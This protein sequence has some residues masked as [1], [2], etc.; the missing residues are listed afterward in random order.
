MASTTLDL[1][2]LLTRIVEETRRVAEAEIAVLLMVD[3]TA[4]ALVA[5][6]VA[7]EEGISMPVGWTIPLDTPGMEVGILARG[8]AYY[9][10]RALD[11]PNVIPAYLPYMEQLGVRNFCG[12]ALRA[13]EQPIGELYVINR[14]AGFGEDEVRLLRALAGYAANAIENARLFEETRQRSEELSAL[15]RVTSAVSR[16]LELEEVLR[17][18]LAQVLTL[19]G[20]EVGLISLVRPATGQMYL[21]VHR[22]LPEPLV[23]RLLEAGMGGTL[24]DLVYQLGETVAVEDLAQGA[25]ADVGGLVE[26]GLRSYL[27]VPLESKGEVLGTL[28]AFGHT[29]RSISPGTQ[30]LM[31]AVG[32]QVGVA[33]ENAR[34]F[35]EARLHAE[36]LAV[37]N[38]LGQALTTRLDV[39]EVLEETYRGVSRLLDA[40]N[41]YIA[42]YDPDSE[43]VSFPLSTEDGE[44]VQWRPR[45]MGQGLTEYIIRNRRPVLIKE[46]LPERLTEMGIEMIGQTALSW[47]GVPLMIGNRVLGVMAIQ[48]YTAPQAYDEHDLDLLVAIAS[49][50]A[51]A[52]Q[53]AHLFEETQAALAE[54]EKLYEAIAELNAAQTYP[55]ILVALRRHTILGQADRNL[56]IDLFDRPWTAE[57]MPEWVEVHARWIT[58][59]AGTLPSRYPMSD[60][61]SVS[62][63]L[64]PDR[65]TLVPDV[66]ADPRLGERVRSLFV[67]EFR[68][69][70][71]IFV[72]LVVGGQWIG[73]INGIYSESLQF[74]EE[75]VRRLWALAGQAAIAVQSIRRLEQTQAALFETEALYRAARVISEATSIEEIVRGAAEIASP[76][77]F[78]ACS[79]TVTTLTDADGVPTHGDIYSVVYSERDW[80]VLPPMASFPIADR[81]AAQRVLDE[82]DFVQIFA[83]IEDPQANIPDEVRET[84]RNVGMRGMVTAGLSIFG[85]A[86]GFLTFT[87]QKPVTGLF[88][89]HVRRI[90]TVAD[91]VAVALADADSSAVTAWIRTRRLPAD[92]P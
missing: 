83:D 53:N 79:V 13:R 88:E 44:R 20:F 28:C 31:Q 75:E 25:P 26:M 1:D 89:E 59:P 29:S 66:E 40:T 7:S 3:R 67:R 58:P 6:H 15:N 74:P 2:E 69:R 38:D 62:A 49:Q 80:V 50:T 92:D 56:T 22:G 57:R 90:R 52:I 71:V 70:C 17:E 18:A 10:N 36:E 4:N 33:V 60:F 61:P 42:L 41:F 81:E 63:L 76:L 47:M 68:A 35:E 48:S 19:T 9:S 32:Q 30:S 12:V 65:P 23:R 34:L 78:E 27:G 5:Q 77:G 39:E 37:L 84:A 87:S 82:P 86:L 24:C 91:Q 73:Y 14:A 8:D 46:D 72:P 64:R 21:A 55:D 11:D 85:R 43:S 45:R 54:T 51:I 16:S